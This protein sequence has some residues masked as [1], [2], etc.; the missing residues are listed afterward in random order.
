MIGESSQ[1]DEQIL[2]SVRYFL[3]KSL[4]PCLKPIFHC[5]SKTLALGCRIGQ[6]PKHKSFALGIPSCWYPKTLKF[7][8]PPTQM[9]K[10]PS[11]PMQTPN[12]NR[13]NNGHVGSLTQNSCVGHVDFILFV[14]N[15][16]PICSEIWASFGCSDL[17]FFQITNTPKF[18]IKIPVANS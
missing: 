17:W 16:N 3:S 6:C 1:I 4:M 8:L 13:W 14:P 18:W 9:L 7:A 15:T 5:D 2:P 12:L 11:T 10:F